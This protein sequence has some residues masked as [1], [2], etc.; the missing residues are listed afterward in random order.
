MD[1]G[2]VKDILGPA[3]SAGGNNPEHVFHAECDVGPVACFHLRHGH[4]EIGCEDGPWEPQVAKTGIVG[5]E[6]RF[7]ELVAIEIHGC[8]L[9][10]RKL[11]AEAANCI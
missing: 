4:D 6:L 2:P 5:L 11:I 10:V 9:A 3:V 7:D 8:D 1:S